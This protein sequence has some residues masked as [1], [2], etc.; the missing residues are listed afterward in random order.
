MRK[1]FRICIRDSTEAEGFFYNIGNSVP[2]IIKSSGRMCRLRARNKS[3]AA[4][5]VIMRECAKRTFVLFKTNSIKQLT[6]VKYC[7]ILF[8]SKG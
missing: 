8:V 7:Y 1:S 6:T 2:Y 4:R 5:N 3:R